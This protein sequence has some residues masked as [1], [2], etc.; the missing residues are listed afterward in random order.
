MLLSLSYAILVTIR[1]LPRVMRCVFSLSIGAIVYC[2]KGTT[3]EH[4]YISLIS[5]HCRTSGLSNDVLHFILRTIR[6][7]YK[8]PSARGALGD[9][10][11]CDLQSITRDLHENGYHVFKQRLSAERCQQLIRLASTNEA[12]LSPE[13]ESLPQK[14]IFNPVKPVADAYKFDEEFLV[15]QP[16]F[17][18]LLADHSI[19]SVVQSY[20]ASA[21]VLSSFGLWWSTDANI[22]SEAQRVLAQQYH[23]DMDKIKWLKIFI[24]LCDVTGDNGPHC[25]IKGSHRTGCQPYQLLKG[26]YTRIS[27]TDIQKFYSDANQV[28]IKG[29]QG[30]IVAVDTR[31]FHK[32]KPILSGARL[33]LS[34][35][36]CSSQFGANLKCLP[37]TNMES[38]E[39]VEVITKYPRIFSRLKIECDGN[40][41][42]RQ[43]A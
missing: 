17:Q 19:L 9:L 4:A 2:I 40:Y 32:G 23:F 13:V 36:Y 24:Y 1:S 42:N 31:G 16:L 7:P 28:E 37:I 12:N 10:S 30:T 15:N 25:F 22:S 39:F 3:P 35:N 26:G 5:L 43:A 29:L 41:Q 34:L 11:K 20:L 6:R 18:E 27:D 14:A 8:L 21:P 33:L 38:Q